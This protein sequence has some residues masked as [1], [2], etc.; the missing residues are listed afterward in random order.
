[1]S[2]VVLFAQ[3][4]G[5]EVFKSDSQ[6]VSYSGYDIVDNQWGRHTGMTRI[7]KKGKAHI[8]LVLFMHAFSVLTLKYPYFL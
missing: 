3:T 2:L 1:M 5:F 7:T 8:R 4:N 6:L